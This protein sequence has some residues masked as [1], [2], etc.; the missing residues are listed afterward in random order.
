VIG[1]ARIGNNVVVVANSLVMTNVPDNTTVIG[2]PARIRL[3]R[4]RDDGGRSITR[5]I[6]ERMAPNAEKS[7]Q[8]GS[9]PTNGKY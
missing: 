8:A 5:V 9:I 2:V 7:S 1:H 4:G 6:T 3:P